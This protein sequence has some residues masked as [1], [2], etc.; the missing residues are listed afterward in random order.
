MQNEEQKNYCSGDCCSFFKK[1]LWRFEVQLIL[2]A[3]SEILPHIIFVIG[4]N[5]EKRLPTFFVILV[6][7]VNY[8]P[9]ILWERWYKLNGYFITGW[10]ILSIILIC[11][12]TLCIN[13]FFIFSYLTCQNAEIYL[14]FS[15][16]PLIIFMSIIVVSHWIKNDY[17]VYESA[18]VTN[19]MPNIASH[20]DESSRKLLNTNLTI[21]TE[22][23]AT[24]RFLNFF[25]KHVPKFKNDLKVFICI[26]FLWI[27]ALAVTPLFK[28]KV[29]CWISYSVF[30]WYFSS[31]F[32]I[33]GTIGFIRKL[34]TV[35]LILM[36]I[37]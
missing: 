8:L 4:H 16:F 18:N 29:I 14:Q 22:K 21:P 13:S 30:C 35:F 3:L 5:N 25:G 34:Y 2:L 33:L 19:N 15:L 1:L 11:V 26:S 9:F 32:F 20:G 10:S 17:V 6:L 24:D 31:F 7:V 12:L 27:I 36:K 23:S 37:K 28:R